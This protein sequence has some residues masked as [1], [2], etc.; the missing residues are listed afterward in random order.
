MLV[1]VEVPLGYLLRGTVSSGSTFRFYVGGNSRRRR[2]VS[3]FF[4]EVLGFCLFF[5]C[6]VDL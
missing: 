3:L 1:Q 6:F 5:V 4:L 2:I